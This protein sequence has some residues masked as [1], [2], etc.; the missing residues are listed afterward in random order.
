M[1]GA[2]LLLIFVLVGI[3]FRANYKFLSGIVSDLTDR[4]GRQSIFGETVRETFYIL[5]LNMLWIV[6]CGALLYIGL[7]L[8]Q[9]STTHLP[10]VGMGVTIGCVGVYAVWEWITYWICGN[11]FS[12]SRLTH[13]WLCGLRASQGLASL[14]LLPLALGAM[15]VP[16]ASAVLLCIAVV[17]Y[18]LVRLVYIWQGFYIFFN[19]LGGVV[20]FFYYLCALEIAPLPLVYHA[21]RNMCDVIG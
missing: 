4:G 5:T 2:L 12:N 9:T 21:A 7:G 19:R 1:G 8:S 20:P 11:V 15:F 16:S 3:R 18:A 17:L 14:G 13:V 6:S 10:T